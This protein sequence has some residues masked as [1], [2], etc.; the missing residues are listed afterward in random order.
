M[1]ETNKKPGK[2]AIV[3]VILLLLGN[4]LLF[5]T[6]W[7]LQ[8]YDQICLDQ[9]L[10]QIKTSSSGVNHELAAGAVLYVGGLGISAS[11]IEAFVYLLL[12]GRLKEKLQRNRRYIEYCAT[13]VCRFFKK[14]A[15]TLASILFASCIAFFVVQLDVLA[16][17]GTTVYAE[18]DFIEEHYADP[19]TAKLTFP[20]K[21]RNLVYIFLESM[22]N[23]YADTSAGEPIYVNYIPELTALAKE[24]VSFSH[25]DGLGGAYSYAGTTW[26]ASAMVA[27]TSG[28]P[29]KVPVLAD[30]YGSD[31]GFMP[32]I[33]SIGE[34]LVGEGYNISLLMGSDASFHGKESYFVEHGDYH[35][36]D[37]DSL[38]EEGRLPEDYHE[39]WGFEDE[40]LFAFAK[41]EL[42]S[43]A[44]EGKPFSLTMLTSDTHFPD[45]YICPD[46][47]NEHES[48]YSNV[49]SCS[50]KRVYDFVQWIKEQPFYKDTTIVIVGD[51]LTMDAN[52]LED[53]DE[54]Y[55]RT[56][57]NCIINSAVEPVS[58]KNRE[59]GT[60]DMFPTTLAAMGVKIEGDRLALGT[61]LFSAEK[62]LTEMYGFEELDTELQKNSDF[63]NAKFLAMEE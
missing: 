27:Q 53:L 36:V 15:L 37:T 30:A 18:S 2:K 49:L 47:G 14:R 61:N 17:V 24:N 28:L 12:S 50:S 41:E 31:E 8:K 16:Y 29:I 54:N 26:T 59:Y 51:H 58:D 60:F 52:F 11:V 43:L 48:Q 20:E 38:K 40:K 45:G 19:E 33:T 42:T 3:S 1:A 32:G 5:L 34:I 22:E 57:Y 56:V 62:T 39:W 44:E 9:C 21:K 4:I 6:L 25:N 23:T 55:V 13:S 35:I 7:L 10:F 63:Y 46:C